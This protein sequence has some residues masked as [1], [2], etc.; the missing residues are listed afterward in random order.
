MA[1]RRA[2]ELLHGP[3]NIYATAS[4]QRT[5]VVAKAQP[6]LVLAARAVE[7]I[8]FCSLHLSPP[9]CAVLVRGSVDVNSW[10]LRQWREVK[11]NESDS[12]GSWIVHKIASFCKHTR[13]KSRLALGLPLPSTFVPEYPISLA[14][15]PWTGKQAVMTEDLWAG[16][17]GSFEGD[18]HPLDGHFFALDSSIT[19]TKRYSFSFPGPDRLC[20]QWAVIYVTEAER[21]SIGK[22]HDKVANLLATP[23][24]GVPDIVATEH[25]R[26]TRSQQKGQTSHDLPPRLRLPYARSPVTLLIPLVRAVSPWLGV[27]ATAL[28]LSV[29]AEADDEN[30]LCFQYPP[31]NWQVMDRTPNPP[32]CR[33]HQIGLKLRGIPDCSEDVAR[34]LPCSE[35]RDYAAMHTDADDDARGTIVYLNHVAPSAT[36]LT[37][38][39]YADLVIAGGANGGPMIR[40]QTFSPNHA[41][42]VHMD[43]RN[44]AHGN[45]GNVAPDTDF[46]QARGISQLRVL[47]YSRTEISR[48][49]QFYRNFP[50]KHMKHGSRGMYLATERKRLGIS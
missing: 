43:F 10:F 9:N 7:S 14:T 50:D 42:A 35:G 36:G 19:C 3:A 15:H 22:I 37:S 39:P 16:S 33:G 11:G 29:P 12:S 23:G 6:P 26:V 17:P 5:R 45:V 32:Y 44:C 24:V 4:D 30:E 28:G 13:S 20:V 38:L 48:V 49:C 8:C 1:A 25:N 18:S 46:S 41:V 47:Y 31:T 34:R 2:L 27:A 40:I 21:A